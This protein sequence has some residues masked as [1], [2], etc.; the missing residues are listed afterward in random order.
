MSLLMSMLRCGSTGVG[1][2]FLFLA[3][4]IHI[5]RRPRIWIAGG[6]FTTADIEHFCEREWT[7]QREG[8]GR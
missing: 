8:V 5:V 3:A 1:R 4:A 6:L 2:I 7:A